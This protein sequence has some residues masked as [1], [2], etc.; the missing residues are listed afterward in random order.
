LQKIITLDETLKRDGCLSLSECKSEFPASEMLSLAQHLGTHDKPSRGF[1]FSSCQAIAKLRDKVCKAIVVKS[2]SL[3][4]IF[5]IVYP[6]CSTFSFFIL[7]F[8]GKR[9]AAEGWRA[10]HGALAEDPLRAREKEARKC[11]I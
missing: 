8:E 6:F 4:P 2:R 11:N 9:L 5:K 7:A 3:A 1:C 10:R